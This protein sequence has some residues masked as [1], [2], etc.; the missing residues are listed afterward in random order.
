MCN[1]KADPIAT[2]LK[3]CVYEVQVRGEGKDAHVW[4]EAPRSSGE[5]AKGNG[6]RRWELVDI[7]G[8]SE[9][10]CSTMGWSLRVDGLTDAE[11]ADPPVPSI[12]ALKLEVPSDEAGPSRRSAPATMSIALPDDLPNSL[13]AFADLILRTANAE[14]KCILTKEAV[15]RMRTGELKSIRPSKSEL[16]KFREGGGLLD[17]P[18]R[19]VDM[20]APDKTPKRSAGF[21]L[22]AR[23]AGCS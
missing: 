9:G 14:L 18:P 6:P 4:V 8:V 3:A 13:L 2:G 21:D 17:E 12:A 23:Y 7:R 20:V 11:F 15:R 10:M 16:Q 22:G 5:D 1:G 19:E